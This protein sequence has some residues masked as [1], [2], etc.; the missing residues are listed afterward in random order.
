MHVI[1]YML[2]FLVLGENLTAINAQTT[3]STSSESSGGNDVSLKEIITT[4]KFD[5]V[6]YLKNNQIESFFFAFVIWFYLVTLCY[7]C[8]AWYDDST[9]SSNNFGVY[10]DKEKDKT[11]L[12]LFWYLMA[13]SDDVNALMRK[14]VGIVAIF[15]NLTFL[16]ISLIYAIAQNLT[17][18]GVAKIIFSLVFFIKGSMTINMAIKKD[19]KE[20]EKDE[21]DNSNT[22]GHEYL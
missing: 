14:R 12:S 20:S 4:G 17:I 8:S 3:N 15:R 2:I 16:I 18:S 13:S 10:P 11:T 21:V 7:T 1:I 19:R 5:F 6:G 22:L 9:G